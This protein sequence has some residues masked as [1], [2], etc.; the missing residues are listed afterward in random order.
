M[1]P[2]FLT[3]NSFFSGIGG[4][5]LAFEQAGIIPLFQCEID[6][7]CQRVLAEH[8]PDLE[9]AGDIKTV[10]SRLLPEADIWC[11]GFPCQDVSVARG[12]LKRHGLRGKQS[13]LFFP[14]IWLVRAKTP[15]VVFIENVQ[16]LLN[17]HQGADF[18]IVLD[19]LSSMGYGVAWR[20][21]NSRVPEIAYCLAATSGRHTG[22]D[23]SRS[24][25]SYLDG[26]KIIIGLPPFSVFAPFPEALAEVHPIMWCAF[27]SSH[28]Y[29]TFCRVRREPRSY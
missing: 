6:A 15:K 28:L 21:L 7:F 4:F 23:W 24:Y 12:S 25:V 18:T 27:R 11:G 16:G 19:T 8:W 22:T 9:I 13:G 20:V 2:W 3:C 10:K 1:S 14:F 29:S 26:G 17:S 5:D